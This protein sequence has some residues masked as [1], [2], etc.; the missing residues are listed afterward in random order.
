MPQSPNPSSCPELDSGLFQ[1]L[2]NALH[3]LVFVMCMRRFRNRSG[4]TGRGFWASLSLGA[5]PNIS[6]RQ[7][8]CYCKMFN[9]VGVHDSMCAE[10]YTLNSL[11]E[12]HAKDHTINNNSVCKDLFYSDHFFLQFSGSYYL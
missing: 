8:Y 3:P 4:M 5:L 10:S 12:K 2:S 7:V 9:F 6:I 1:D 11:K